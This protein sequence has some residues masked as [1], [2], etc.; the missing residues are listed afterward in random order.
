MISV[1][2]STALDPRATTPNSVRVGRVPPGCGAPARFV[3]VFRDEECILRVD[4][5]DAQSSAF[6]DAILWANHVVIGFA[7]EVHFVS[8]L[9]HAARSVLLDSYYCQLYPTEHYL[10][11]ASG[12]RLLRVEPDRHVLWRSGVLG[13]DGVVVEHA[14]PLVIQGTGEW[15]PPGG[16]RSFALEAPS[17]RPAACNR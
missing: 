1:T 14:D 8:L 15:D 5:H 3:A 11:V 10:L 16:W 7:D 6:E 17:G 9:D 2:M 12:E 4:V 13:I